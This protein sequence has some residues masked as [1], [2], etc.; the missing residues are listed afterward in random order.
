VVSLTSLL[1][2][3]ANIEHEAVPTDITLFIRHKKNIGVT[4]HHK[5]NGFFS[6]AFGFSK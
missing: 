6:R 2:H 5:K 1:A 4:L 3:P